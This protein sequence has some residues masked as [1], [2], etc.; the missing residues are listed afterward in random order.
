MGDALSALEEGMPFGEVVERWTADPVAR[1]T[2]GVTPLI[3][4]TDRASVG[5]LASRLEVGER[6]GPV[7]DSAGCLFFE[8]VEKQEV[9]APGETTAG[10]WLREAREELMS[11][12]ARGTMTIFLGRAG[13]DRGFQVHT[14]RLRQVRVSSVPTLT[15]RSLGFG[16]RMLA[17]PVVDPQLDWLSAEPPAGLAVP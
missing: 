6:F 3:A 13:Q 16:G 9:V 8:V 12:E 15:F 5:M 7:R 10:S 2:Q 4:I 17:L 14:D 11:I 1:A